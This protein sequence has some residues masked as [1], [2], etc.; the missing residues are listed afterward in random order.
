MAQQAVQRTKHPAA[1]GSTYTNLHNKTLLLPSVTTTTRTHKKAW[2]ADAT[3]IAN[4]GGTRTKKR[5]DR[6]SVIYYEL[7]N[8]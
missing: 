7:A 6:T 3:C 8:H 2:R 5:K 4:S 1:A